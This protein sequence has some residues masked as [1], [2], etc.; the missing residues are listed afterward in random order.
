MGKETQSQRT[1]QGKLARV[2][3]LLEQQGLHDVYAIIVCAELYSSNPQLYDSVIER[4]NDIHF[5]FKEDLESIQANI[6]AVSMHEDML[7]FCRIL[8][9]YALN[10]QIYLVFINRIQSTYLI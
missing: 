3:T 1:S 7:R 8:K 6:D 4:F 10:H 9:R 2:K 5:L